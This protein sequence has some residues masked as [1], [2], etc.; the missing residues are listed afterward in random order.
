MVVH[1]YAIDDIGRHAQTV[2]QFVE[3][4]QE[5]FFDNLQVAEITHGQIV[6]HQRD[7]LGETLQLVRLRTDELE[8]IGV[9]LMRHNAGASGAFLGKFYKTE[10]LTIEHAGIKG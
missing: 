4:R 5:Y 1:L 6:H 2:E 3:S 7:L 10:V 8:D 9:L